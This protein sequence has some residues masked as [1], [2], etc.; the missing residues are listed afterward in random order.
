MDKSISEQI[1]GIFKNNN[2]DTKKLR[3][4]NVGGNIFKLC[5]LKKFITYIET[6]SR[7]DTTKSN[8]QLKLWNSFRRDLLEHTKR[9]ETNEAIEV[10]CVIDYTENKFVNKTIQSLKNQTKEPYIVLIISSHNEKNIAVSNNID[11]YWSNERTPYTR[12]SDCVKSLRSS[13]PRLE[14]IMLCNSGDVFEDSWISQTLDMINNNDK[15]I[16]GKN[17]GYIVDGSN[18]YDIQINQDYGKQII[19]SKHGWKDAVMIN[20]ITITKSMLTM[21]KWN[22]GS[23]T[24]INNI[25]FGIHEFA[26]N[27]KINV[28]YLKN[29]NF[30]SLLEDD[31]FYNVKD[32]LANRCFSINKIK[33]LPLKNSYIY[34][35]LNIEIRDNR[36]S[37]IL[38][39]NNVKDTD[40]KDGS[41]PIIYIKKSKHNIP[42]P[43]K[44]LIHIKPK[45]GKNK[46]EDTDSEVEKLAKKPKIPIILRSN[47]KQKPKTIPKP[48]NL[49]PSDVK[50]KEERREQELA[51]EKAKE[52][53]KTPI[54]RPINTVGQLTSPN[55]II[56]IIIMHNDKSV[57]ELCLKHV[58]SQ[59]VK[60]DILLVVPDK[61]MLKS[62]T[63]LNVRMIYVD[64]DN[65]KAKI[66][67]AI[68]YVRNLNPFFV[69]IIYGND[70]ISENWVKEGISRI[71]KFDLDVVGLNQ[72]FIYSDSEKILLSKK[73]KPAGLNYVPTNLKDRWVTL[74]G[75]IMYNRILHRMNWNIFLN[76]Y[77]IDTETSM[78]M[79]FVENGAKI[80]N[81]CN[82]N[83]LHIIKNQ[84]DLELLKNNY[85]IITD[86]KQNPEMDIPTIKNIHSTFEQVLIN[87]EVENPN[88]T[89]VILS[90]K[91]NIPE[92][93]DLTTPLMIDYSKIDKLNIFNLDM[94]LIR[95][96]ELTQDNKIVQSLWIGERLGL[97]EQLCIMSFLKHGHEFHLYTYENVNGIP[98]GTTILDGNKILPKS[99][100]FYYSEQQSLSGKRS[101]VAFS[102]MFRYKM[103]LD[104]GGYWVDMDMICV[105]PFNFVEDY[106]F[107]SE[108]HQGRQTINAGVIKCPSGSDFAGYCYD[109]CRKKDKNKIKWGEIGPALVRESVE[110]HKL[111]HFVKS[112]DVF[113][114][115]GIDSVQN[116]VDPYKIDI[117]KRWYGIHLWNEIWRKNGLNKEKI[118]LEFIAE[119]LYDIKFE[120]IVNKSGVM[121]IW[122]PMNEFYNQFHN[123]KDNRIVLNQPLQDT[124]RLDSFVENDLYLE[125]MRRLQQKNM[126]DDIHVVFG[127]KSGELDSYNNKFDLFEPTY[128]KYR[129]VHF[130]KVHNLSDMFLFRKATFIFNRGYYDKLYQ[131]GEF[132]NFHNFVVTYPATALNQMVINGKIYTSAPKH[133]YTYPYDI[134]FYDERDKIDYFKNMF[135][136]AKSFAD[137]NKLGFKY[138]G[139]EHQRIYDIIYCGSTKYPTKNTTL[140]LEYLN[141]LDREKISVKICFA[142]KFKE[143]LPKYKHIFVDLFYNVDSN[144]MFE[145]F[146]V[147]K[148]N[149][150]FS[151]RDANPR[152]ISESLSCGCYCICLGTL[153]DGYSIFKNN[154]EFGKIVTS[155]YLE[156]DE[157]LSACYEPDNTMFKQITDELVKEKNYQNIKKVF[158]STIERSVGI[159]TNH[160]ID[161]YKK[162]KN[163]AY[164]LTLAT[165]DYMKPMNY[166]LASI[167]HSNPLVNVVVICVNCNKQIIE[168]FCTHYKK[169]TFINYNISKYYNKGDILKLKVDIQKYYFHQ[170]RKPF[171]WID[172]DTVVV[173]KLDSL[174]YNI[175]DYNMM[176]YPRFDNEN[177]MKF[178]VGVIGFGYGTD[179]ST[180]YMLLDEYSS[181][182]KKVKGVNDWFYD[183]IALWKVYQEQKVKLKVY[184]LK[185]SEHTLYMDTNSIIISRRKQT[186]NEMKQ[187]LE[188][189]NCYIPR[190]D[191]SGIQ[192]VY[193]YEG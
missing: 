90:R 142:S 59:S 37:T 87:Y 19:A 92:P 183:Q 188:S 100:I 97:V 95:T 82:N 126:I 31:Y 106:V 135:P 47:L 18:I 75:R 107:S 121:I 162:S 101:P 68:S 144:K 80:G 167:Q 64:S 73:L 177:Y 8:S 9:I 180:T 150:I 50:I 94:T 44:K 125:L 190:I 122:L 6:I 145:L 17:A 66:S 51:M 166:L 110:K 189:L 7:S 165:Q 182:V 159:Q 147:S 178:A 26:V 174:L 153:S 156:L 13:I 46:D 81:M 99:E 172:A 151:G 56:T 74:N 191:F 163:G 93:S 62:L 117:G 48:A 3:F 157:N 137:F 41:V 170:Y 49:T 148:N 136:R 138:N 186:G 5:Y 169:Y 105:R 128:I 96:K 152:I 30:V 175:Y 129:G 139:A 20:G 181:N 23:V 60:T 83:I 164:I 1:L 55:K 84:L 88:K 176:V 104:K 185:E 42:K 112:W 192:T 155:K 22:V 21:M 45:R 39:P 15:Q 34:E 77:D 161:L 10:I 54:G 108:I 70:L 160:I 141:Y 63:R 36:N 143:A 14:N 120:E 168:D 109:V 124:T 130:W 61:N 71:K 33:E 113:C 28:G 24:F 179:I 103:L 131:A 123:K 119:I 133:R 89:P 29:T 58:K 140:F 154:P 79:K 173:K 158:C 69:C 171:L 78:G 35:D 86:V 4:I 98:I 52:Q 53:I 72:T 11:F 187:I 2:F 116:F 111:K 146:N 149:L 57:M 32:I 132:Y 193:D 115:V 40:S 16:V 43:K 102:N 76:N 118:S 27:K 184:K 114:P 134:V 38:P 67:Q 91:R 25:T 127:V 12:F 65:D 85:Y